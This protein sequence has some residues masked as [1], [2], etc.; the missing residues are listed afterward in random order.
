MDNRY[1]EFKD[2][3]FSKM[4]RD[5][6]REKG[7]K[8]QLKFLEASQSNLGFLDYLML[9]GEFTRGYKDIVLCPNPLTESEF[10]MPPVDTE[11]SFFH[12]WSDLPPRIACRTTFWAN[13]TLHHIDRDRIQASYL[14]ARTSV[15]G[16]ENI[17]GLL[18]SKEADAEGKVLIDR[19]VRRILRRLGGLREA[20]G[21]RS[22]YVD[23]PFARAWWRERL[24]SQISDG[25]LELMQKV[26]DVVR[27]SNDYWEKL[28]V[29]IVSQ[30]SVLGSNTI[31][32]SFI[33]SLAELLAGEP[34]SPLRKVVGIRSACRAIG[35]IQASREL[36]VLDKDELRQ[37][38]DDVVRTQHEKLP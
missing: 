4:R 11:E 17:R 35:S 28:V 33:L 2:Q 37:I 24:V 10:I 14:A 25:N 30:N 34:E 9:H 16:S 32:N 6:L 23:C 19:C 15:S 5:L 21:N 8:H 12:A 18:Q 22:V 13:V 1:E 3:S 29:L 36:S 20:R 31:R 7:S 27:L 38:T 26:R